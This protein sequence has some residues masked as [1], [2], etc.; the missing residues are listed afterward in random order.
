MNPGKRYGEDESLLQNYELLLI[1]HARDPVK[2]VSLSYFG[3]FYVTAMI[4]AAM[5][6]AYEHMKDISEDSYHPQFSSF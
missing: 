2:T 4:V 1:K 5:I 3:W 6:S